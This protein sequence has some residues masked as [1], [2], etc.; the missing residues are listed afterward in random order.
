MHLMLDNTD[1]F[2]MTPQILQNNLNIGKV[3]MT[4]FSLLIFDECHHARKKEPYNMLMKMYMMT[5]N[6][7][8]GAKLPQVG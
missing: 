7:Q 4:D 5:R 3:R 8:R 2:F 1:V 6:E